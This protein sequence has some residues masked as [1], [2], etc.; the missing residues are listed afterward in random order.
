MPRMKDGPDIARVAALFGDPAR[1]N[2]LVAL[3]DGR[4]LTAS[5]LAAEA[6]VTKQ[7]ASSHLARLTNGGFIVVE[8]QGRHRYYRVTDEEVA[9]AIESL[10][11]LAHAKGGRRTRTGPRD[12]ALRHARSCYSHLAGELGV[13]MFNSLARRRWIELADDGVGVT[14]SGRRAFTEFGIDLPALEA[15]HRLLCRP[16]LDWSERRHHLAGSLGVAL[17]QRITDLKWA[18]REKDSRIVRFSPQGER[19]FLKWLG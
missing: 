19:A 2:M 10:M 12:P 16:C 15:L 14:A 18:K 1:A 13:V 3:G 8:P 5:E 7:T 9:H 4:A 6:G 11:G 17:L